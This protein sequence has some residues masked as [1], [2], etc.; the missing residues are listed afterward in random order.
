[1][2][3]DMLEDTSKSARLRKL[4]ALREHL[5]R[6]PAGAFFNTGMAAIY[7]GVSTKTLARWRQVKNMGPPF[8]KQVVAEGAEA[9]TQPYK[10]KK[11]DLDSFTG[12]RMSAGGFAFASQV[13]PWQ[14]NG[15]GA[16]EG[17]ALGL[18]I[19][20][21]AESDPLVVSL[22]DALAEPWATAVA[23]RPY[24]DEL[25]GDMRQALAQVDSNLLTLQLEENTPP[26]SGQ[27]R[28]GGI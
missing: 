14:V 7:L 21:L 17:S 15:S 10:Y 3:D 12:S 1:M 13:E 8:Q 22:L 26:A 16:I 6:M 20:A 11:Q 28:R 24:R 19:E 25:E 23:M 27:G 5:E 2:V 9:S 18:S 4:A